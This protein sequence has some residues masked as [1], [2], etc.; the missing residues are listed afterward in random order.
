MTIAEHKKQENIAEYI[1]Y[2]WQMEDLAR[3]CGFDIGK[4]AQARQN[5]DGVNTQNKEEENWM[6][7]LITSMKKEGIEKIGHLKEVRETLLELYNLHFSLLHGKET[8]D[9]RNAYNLVQ[10]NIDILKAK[11]PGTDN[12]IEISLQAL[13]GIAIL[14]IQHKKISDDTTKAAQ[15]ISQLL[16]LLSREFKSLNYK[17]L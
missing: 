11:N 7:N 1:L 12:V 2:M 15:T 14:K 6:A 4:M 8:E 10:P 9:Y 16:A 17:N 13:Y 3:A 5:L